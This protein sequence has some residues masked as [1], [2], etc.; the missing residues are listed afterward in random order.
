MTTIIALL[1]VAL[2]LFFFEIF[3]PGG[4]L[5]TIGTVCLIASTVL[6]YNAYGVVPAVIQFCL[7]LLFVLFFFFFSLYLLPKTKLG[8]ILILSST[9][10]G[11]KSNVD[12]AQEDI[13]GQTG[14][15]VTTMAPSGTIVVE[16][17]R[18][19]A[20]SL[21]G[22]LRS[23]D[24]VTVVAKDAFKLTVRKLEEANN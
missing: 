2:V 18:Y 12:Q 7:S 5:G 21:N 23:G 24:R 14:E 17:K 13:I 8:K 10:E 20:I 4:I 19:E 11:F 1:L 16:G 3:V 22:L 15:V 6:T 9:Q